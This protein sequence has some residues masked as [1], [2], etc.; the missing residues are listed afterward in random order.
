MSW[1]AGASL[2]TFR[3]GSQAKAPAFSAQCR[4]PKDLPGLG[5]LRIFLVIVLIVVVIVIAEFVLEVVIDVIFI[6][7]REP[8]VD[9][10]RI[11]VRGIGGAH[12]VGSAPAFGFGGAG[13]G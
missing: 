11:I 3:N 13:G 2:G 4:P 12:A 9:F 7:V 10:L 1:K 8:G 6:V 5:I